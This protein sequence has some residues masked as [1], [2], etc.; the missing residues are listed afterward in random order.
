[1]ELLNKVNYIL[2]IIGFGLAA[3]HFVANGIELFTY[4]V[5]AFLLIFCILAGI[6]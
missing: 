4:I 3:N 6:E 1:M 5:P 2:A